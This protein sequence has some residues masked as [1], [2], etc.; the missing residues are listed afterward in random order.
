[1]D[2]Q[3]TVAADPR[4]TILVVD[5][6]PAILVFVSELL[7]EGGHRVLAATD[8]EVALQLAAQYPGEIH[9][10][11]SDFEMPRMSGIVLATAL[12][13]AR[14][15]IKVL[16]MSGF[17]GGTLLLNDGWYFLPKPFVASQL[18]SIVTTLTYRDNS[19]PGL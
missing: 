6:D 7:R 11:L 9:L 1:M 4:K 19:E 13:N 2:E 14:P 16:L 8:G 15:A 12:T 5:D 10:L 18:R 3:Q 17:A